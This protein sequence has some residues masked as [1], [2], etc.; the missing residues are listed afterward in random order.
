M[1]AI[2]T[3]MSYL[4]ARIKTISPVMPVCGESGQ[5][6]KGKR[7]AAISGFPFPS[8]PRS[9]RQCC[10][11]LNRPSTCFPLR[12]W[13]R[14]TDCRGGHS[15]CCL[16]PV[17]TSPKR[18]WQSGVCRWLC[19]SIFGTTGKSEPFTCV[20]TTTLRAAAPPM[21]SGSSW[22]VGMSCGTAFP[23]RA[24]TITIGFA[25]GRGC[26]S[27]EQYQNQRGVWHDERI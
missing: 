27:P 7:R 22:Q 25:C 18:I 16:W 6:S 3:I 11:C 20:S 26:Q 2:P 12:R 19:L 13:R 4:S 9:R 14:R 24:R 21:R 5:T 1:R 15:T 23:A 10:I 8:L 17:C